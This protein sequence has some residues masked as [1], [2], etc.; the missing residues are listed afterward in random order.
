MFG[1]NLA[2]IRISSLDARAKSL[3]KTLTNFDMFIVY[4]RGL[5]STYG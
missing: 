5:F 2:K 4:N 3:Q 1:V